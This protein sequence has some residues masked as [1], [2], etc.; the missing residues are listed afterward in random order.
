[1]LMFVGHQFCSAGSHPSS[2]VQTSS[3]GDH[4][5]MLANSGPWCGMW[6][7][8]RDRRWLA[9]YVK[10]RKAVRWRSAFSR[11]SPKWPKSAQSRNVRE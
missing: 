5:K 1:M 2:I 6:I 11:G 10:H 7:P 8:C 9:S 3:S 4:Y